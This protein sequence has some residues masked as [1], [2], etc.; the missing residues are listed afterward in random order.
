MK[1]VSGLIFVQSFPYEM[2]WPKCQWVKISVS[3]TAKMKQSDLL[4]KKFKNKNLNP[5]TWKLICSD[6]W[7]VGQSGL[8]FV[9]ATELIK[10]IRGLH[11]KYKI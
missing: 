7:D 5:Y 3:A 8:L 4:Q 1:T 11:L 9:A 6:S 10:H 2:V